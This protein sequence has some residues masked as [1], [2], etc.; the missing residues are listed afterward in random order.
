MPWTCQYRRRSD[1]PT[2]VP[3]ACRPDNI[4]ATSA[5]SHQPLS[6]RSPG[7]QFRGLSCAAVPAASRVGRVFPLRATT[8]WPRAP[9]PLVPQARSAAAKAQDDV[10]GAAQGLHR[11]CALIVRRAG[12]HLLEL[13]RQ[14]ARENKSLCTSKG[15]GSSGRDASP[16]T[17]A[18]AR[19]RSPRAS[20][21]NCASRLGRARLIT[22]VTALM[23]FEQSV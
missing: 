6:I 12:R 23:M 4:T 13:S 8:G 16:C 11:V 5:P 10:G 9:P 14:A 3:F 21:N 7:Q 19:C 18:S 17:G 22:S 20:A 2:A 1:I 15:C